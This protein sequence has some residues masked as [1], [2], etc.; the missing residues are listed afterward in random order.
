MYKGS[1]QSHEIVKLWFFITHLLGS[2]FCTT[3]NVLAN[4]AKFAIKIAD[5]A[6]S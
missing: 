2:D 3:K 6:E 1:G 4:G 5:A